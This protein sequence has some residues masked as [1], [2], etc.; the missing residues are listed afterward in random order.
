MMR[1]IRI[2][3]FCV[4]V[5]VMMATMGHSAQIVSNGLRYDI[6][7]DGKTLT[8]TTSNPFGPSLGDVQ[9]YDISGAEALPR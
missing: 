3:L 7:S 5:A 6:N 9:S 2:R 8:L 1:L 4:L